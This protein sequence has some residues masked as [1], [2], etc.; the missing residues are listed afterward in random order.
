[1]P[2]SARYPLRLFGLWR[3]L[4]WLMLAIIVVLMAMPTPKLDVQV[5]FAD[6][7]VHIA[8]FAWL[9]AWLAQ[10]Y[11]PSRDLWL[12]GLGLI[13]FAAGTELMQAVIPWR[14]GDLMDWMADVI[15]VLL[16]LLVALTPAARSLAWV[17][18]RLPGPAPL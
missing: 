7:W 1:M 18:R 14:S 9:A 5:A 15:G 4:G 17:E 13:A 10:L 16:G 3:G 12:R 2:N 8:A 6:K 11:R